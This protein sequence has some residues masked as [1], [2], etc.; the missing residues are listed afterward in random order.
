VIENFGWLTEGEL[1]GSGGLIHHEELM[2]GN[3]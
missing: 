2:L 3:Q 1:A